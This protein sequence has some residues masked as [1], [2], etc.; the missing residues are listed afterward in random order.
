L[1]DVGLTS[2]EI[3]YRSRAA[4]AGGIGLVSVTAA[5]VLLIV[6]LN[7]LRGSAAKIT[8]PTKRKKNYR[9]KRLLRSYALL[10]L[11]VLLFGVGGAKLGSTGTWFAY[12]DPA[13]YACLGEGD[14]NTGRECR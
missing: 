5:I 3:A 8:L 4:F 13:G 9:T 7:S 14:G 2:L 12:F 1:D 6:G 10:G 11:S